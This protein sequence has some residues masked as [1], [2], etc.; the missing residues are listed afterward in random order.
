[1]GEK[2]DGT[3]KRTVSKIGNLYDVSPVYNAAYSKTSVYMRGKDIAEEE[4][5]K[6]QPYQKNIIKILRNH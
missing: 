6:R 2:N 1:M 3:W 5:R 4:L